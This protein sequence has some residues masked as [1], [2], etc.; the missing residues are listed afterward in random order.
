MCTWATWMRGQIMGGVDMA[1]GHASRGA[2][3]MTVNGSGPVDTYS[4]IIC[5]PHDP[6]ERRSPA[7]ARECLAL[8]SEV[9]SLGPPAGVSVSRSRRPRAGPRPPER[10]RLGGARTKSKSGPRRSET[11]RDRS[12]QGTGDRDRPRRRPVITFSV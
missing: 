12:A 6:S 11:E 5:L 1:H 4:R 3:G 7:T 2:S 8:T 9:E 10:S